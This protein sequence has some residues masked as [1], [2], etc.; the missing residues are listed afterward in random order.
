[1]KP[2]IQYI[3]HHSLHPLPLLQLPNVQELLHGQVQHGQISDLVVIPCHLP[4]HRLP[5]QPRSCY[6]HPISRPPLER[7]RGYVRPAGQQRLHAGHHTLHPALAACL[8]AQE[9]QT[10]VFHGRHVEHV[11][12]GEA[13]Q[14]RAFP[15]HV[16]QHPGRVARLGD[17]AL[18]DGDLDAAEH[19]RGGQP[20]D[21]SEGFPDGGSDVQG[22]LVAP[23]QRA[24]VDVAEAFHGEKAD[25]AV[26][27]AGGFFARGAAY[28]ADVVEDVAGRL[29]AGLVWR[30]GV[31]DEGD[32]C[33]DGAAVV[34]ADLANVP[35]GHTFAVHSSKNL[36]HQPAVAGCMSGLVWVVGAVPDLEVGFLPV[37]SVHVYPMAAEPVERCKIQDE[38]SRWIPGLET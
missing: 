1:M 20:G 10:R 21:L 9:D 16:L 24:G 4:I 23:V 18:R 35:A 19:E 32:F 12:A 14:G 29:R 26:V 28:A 2:E 31:V 15:Q 3:D 8:G 17:V 33:A 7:V 13:R 11:R 25:G 37:A 22:V 38:I 5:H 30:R 36:L 6:K 34:V 27:V